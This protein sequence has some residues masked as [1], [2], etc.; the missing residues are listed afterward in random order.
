MAWIKQTSIA[1]AILCLAAV[2]GAV[3]AEENDADR[4]KRPEWMLAWDEGLPPEIL[5]VAKEKREVNRKK[6]YD[7][8]NWGVAAKYPDDLGLE[9]D[10]AVLLKVDFDDGKVPMNSRDA[11]AGVAWP[12]TTRISE[13]E[14]VTG[15]YCAMN[16]WKGGATGGTASRWHLG[17]PDE[18]ERPAYFMRLYHKFDGDWYGEGK[19]LGMKGFGFVIQAVKHNA[20]L[21]CDGKNWFGSELQWVG[22]GP[23]AKPGTYKGLVIQGHYY[24]YMPYPGEVVAS[25]GEELRP[26]E[27]R[28]SAYNTAWLQLG[29]WYCFEVAVYP[30]TPG[31][32]D[33]EGRL[34]INGV[35]RTRITNMRYRDVANTFKV[36]ATINNYRTQNGGTTD[37]VRRWLDNVVVSRRYIGPIKFSNERLKYLVQNGTVVHTG[38]EPVLKS[39]REAMARKKERSPGK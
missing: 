7:E 13:E 27:C 30:N 14:P 39:M 26:S 17:N 3:G 12:S 23:S 34:W 24:S 2:A 37:D 11:W 33:G 38:D 8:I 1:A 9:K 35:L 32:A 25:L 22:W 10:P 31:K 16:E 6:V 19:V 5:S 36:Y 18:R 4:K 20:D 28:F 15:K 21:K 29:E